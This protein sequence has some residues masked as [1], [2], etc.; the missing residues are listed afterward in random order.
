MTRKLI[1]PNDV[2]VIVRPHYTMG[3]ND[4]V[5]E[6]V[7]ALQTKKV[8]HSVAYAY[9]LIQISEHTREQMDKGLP[10]CI[11]IESRKLCSLGEL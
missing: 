6:L 9:V 4:W 10:V 5:G 8:V 3:P 11:W 1:K 7:L 2:V